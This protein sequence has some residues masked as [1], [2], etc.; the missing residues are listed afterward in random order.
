MANNMDILP[1]PAP[2]DGIHHN[3]WAFWNGV[4]LYISA[5]L[6]KLADNKNKII[7]VFSLLTSREAA[8]FHSQHIKDATDDQGVITFGT[9]TR[10]TTTLKDRFESREERSDALQ[11]RQ[12]LRFRTG[13]FME[14]YVAWFKHLLNMTKITE[15]HV[16]IDLFKEKLLHS[17]L[18]G[19]FVTDNPPTIIQDTT[20]WAITMDQH[21]R[22]IQGKEGKWPHF[23]LPYTAPKKWH[24]P[25]AMDIDHAEQDSDNDEEEIK[26]YPTSDEDSDD[27]DS[28][29]DSSDEESNINLWAVLISK[30]YTQFKNAKRMYKGQMSIHALLTKNQYKQYKE[31]CCITCGASGHYARDCPK[32]KK[33]SHFSKKWRFPP[34]MTKKKLQKTLNN[35]N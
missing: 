17:Y 22:M 23:P 34:K 31:E 2:F 16:A 14:E 26:Y 1:K 28:D 7:F 8:S 3:F 4:Q 32:K 35:L 10:F 15:D 12:H 25:Y 21:H 9:F 24:D 27:D 20:Q 29:E 6:T 30:L 33:S 18:M 5:N 19:I 11:Q 13:T